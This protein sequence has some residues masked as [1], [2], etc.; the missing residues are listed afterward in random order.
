MTMP[1]ALTDARIGD[2]FDC[3]VRAIR[4]CGFAMLPALLAEIPGRAEWDAFA[5]DWN[6]LPLDRHMGDGG[7]YRRRRYATF[8]AARGDIERL[9]HRA[10]YQDRCVNPLTGGYDRWFAPLGE[11]LVGSRVFRNALRRA[12][13]IV[14]RLGSPAARAWSI[15]AH[16]FRIE[17]TSGQAGLPTPEGP[18]R[19]G[20]DWVFIMVVARHNVDGGETRLHDEHGLVRW[21]RRLA[22]GE[23]L[24]IDDR[25]FL[26]ST[27][28]INPREF[29]AAAQRDVLVLTFAAASAGQPPI[30]S[31]RVSGAR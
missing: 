6:R 11:H 20:R 24:L 27:S 16:Q 30:L 7:R 12:L 22:P 5:G 28:P 26:H 9:P 31:S 23:C 13:D 4:T 19:D 14:E 15:E 10:H 21:S 3:T 1:P 8:H 29:G 18:H 2:A 25:R 17:A